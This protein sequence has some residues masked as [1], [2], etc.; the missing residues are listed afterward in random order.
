MERRKL[1]ILGTRMF[2]EE[3]A[4]LA[5]EMPDVEV[6]GLVENLERVRCVNPI[7][8]YRVY[9]IDEIAALKDSHWVICAIGTTHRT[10]YIQQALS[11]GM[12]FTTLVHPTARVS[13][14]ATL[15]VGTFVSALAVV[16]AHSEVGEHTIINRGALLGHHLKMGNFCTVGPGVKL[17]G[18]SVYG[19]QV[20]CGI[21][22]TVVD[23]RKIGSRAVIG[24]GS[25]VTK[26][27]E[28]D[29]VAYG[30]PAKPVRDSKGGR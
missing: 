2:A 8:G 23:Y 11:L 14:K 15:G 13:T 17:G 27:L 5:S 18:A 1:L 30:V 3:V 26:D 28:C 12:R 25:V 24:A 22:S 10:D 6:C 9:W 29:V 21:G 20:Y 7:D 19:D 16:S 4:D